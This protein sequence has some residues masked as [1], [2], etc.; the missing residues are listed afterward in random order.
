M[1]DV[2]YVCPYT[3]EKLTFDGKKYSSESGRIFYVKNNIPRFCSDDNYSKSFGFQWNIYDR[4]QLD[5][6]SESDLSANRFWAATN[7][8]QEILRGKNV[9][10][11]GSGAGRFTQ[12]F[13]QSTKE[14]LYSLD[15]SSAVEANLRN[16][17]D[18][19]SRLRL[20]RA[21][22]YEMPFR[23]NTF[24][25]IFCFGVLQHTPSFKRSIEALVKKLKINGEVVVDFYPSKGFI[26]RIHSK[27]FLR[28]ITKRIPKQIL[29]K[30]IRNTIDISLFLFDLMCFLRI[31][32]LIRFLPITD[33]RGFPKNLTTYQRKKWAIMDT[34]D[35]LSPEFDNPQ[36][37]DKVIQM[38]KEL[39]CVV[40]YGGI[41][42]YEGGSTAVIRAI[43]R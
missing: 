33:I 28:P 42:N 36:K 24:D 13:L 8:T 29:H 18:N 15:Y 39:G 4:T 19:V 30:I 11:V 32:F 16:N 25:K 43:K 1:N 20:V 2:P 31:G 17:F 3:N 6:Y 40:N 14:K 27:Y 35:A 5:S 9:L 34:F 21:S 7:W 10:E 38:F 37:I 41:V 26:T 22:I 12:V 23:D